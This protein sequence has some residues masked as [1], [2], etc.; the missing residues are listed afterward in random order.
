[1]GRAALKSNEAN[2][3]TKHTSNLCGVS[4]ERYTPSSIGS[5]DKYSAMTSAYF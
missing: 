1:M 3:K 5:G 2:Y 4:L